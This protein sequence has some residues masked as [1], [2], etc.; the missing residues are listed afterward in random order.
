MCT[1]RPCS[2]WFKTT[3]R[4]HCRSQLKRR[5]MGRLQQYGGYLKDLMTKGTPSSIRNACVQK[6][7]AIRELLKNLLLG[8]LKLTP[9]QINHLKSRAPALRRAA[10]SCA[11]CRRHARVV[12]ETLREVSPQLKKII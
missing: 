10:D 5:T 9:E 7:M 12:L 2:D 8:N 3:G 6:I 1:R 11:D 4:D